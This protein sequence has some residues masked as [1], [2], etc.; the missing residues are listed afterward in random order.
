MISNW[1]QTADIH[2]YQT[3]F[4]V[5]NGR[6]KRVQHDNFVIF[7]GS[8][9]TVVTDTYRRNMLGEVI[10]FERSDVIVQSFLTCSHIARG[11]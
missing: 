7:F 4:R 2:F 11:V 6:P 3:Y 1:R 10:D 9:C 5:Y 8:K